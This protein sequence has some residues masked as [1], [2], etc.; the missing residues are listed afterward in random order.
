MKPLYIAETVKQAT[1]IIYK[2]EVTIAYTYRLYVL[3]RKMNHY[4][5]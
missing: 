2:R 1:H 5:S 4:V 3:V